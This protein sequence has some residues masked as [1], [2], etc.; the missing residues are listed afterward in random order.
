[1]LSWRDQSPLDSCPRR[2]DGRAELKKDNFGYNAIALTVAR[3][4]CSRRRHA[5]YD[6]SDVLDDKGARALWE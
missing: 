6:S 5:C 1:M 3:S 2:N 4:P